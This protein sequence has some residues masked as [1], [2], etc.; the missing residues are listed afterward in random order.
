M[1]SSQAVE[2][3]IDEV[4]RRQSVVFSEC[5]DDRNTVVQDG[6]TLN[7]RPLLHV[8]L[9]LGSSRFLQAA[10]EFVATSTLGAQASAFCGVATQGIPIATACGLRTGRDAPYLRTRATDYG[11]PDRLLGGS[12]PSDH[13]A[14]LLVDNVLY[15]GQTVSNAERAAQERGW[16]VLGSLVLIEF[17]TP[18]WRVGLANELKS[19]LSTKALLDGLFRRGAVPEPFRPYVF[20]FLE[21]QTAFHSESELHHRWVAEFAKVKSGIG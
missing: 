16:V 20:A 7:L 3:C 15:S 19:M 6:V 2:T 14:V 21:D 1:R 4:A 9:P 11:G 18:V 10:S 5:V 17:E 12:G 8:G 13:S